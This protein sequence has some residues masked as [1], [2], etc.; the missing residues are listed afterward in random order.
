M[1]RGT[2]WRPDVSGYKD[3]LSL[4]GAASL[5]FSS[6]LARLGAAMIG[7]GVV[8]MLAV[9]DYGFGVAGGV[10]AAGMVALAIC[11]P[12]VGRRL[13]VSDSR[14]FLL[15]VG[16]VATTSLLGL[17]LAASLS[18][19]VW[20]LVLVYLP[21]GVQPQVGGLIRAEW[22]RRMKGNGPALSAAN[23]Y[24]QVVE[25]GCYLAGPALSGLLSALWFPEAGVV[26][27][28]ACFLVGILVL[29]GRYSWRNTRG[30]SSWGSDEEN[31]KAPWRNAPL[32]AVS[33]CA[34]FLGG[35][36]GSYD[37]LAIAA[38]DATGRTELGGLLIGT[39]AAGSL[40]GGLT[41]GLLWLGAHPSSRLMVSLTGLAIATATLPFLP[42]LSWQFPA[43]FAVGVFVA[44][45]LAAVMAW[46]QRL[47]PNG[48]LVEGMSIVSTGILLGVALSS[49]VAGM[50]TERLPFPGDFVVTVAFAVL[51]GLVCAVVVRRQSA[52]RVVA[53]VGGVRAE[54]D[55]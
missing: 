4:S 21:F 12:L 47:V 8:T 30:A 6:A 13:D 52:G 25:E 39:L 28:S 33:V 1:K 54:T 15:M 16:G 36:F 5:M 7:V 48:R 31:G 23:S 35:V 18:A 34:L 9:Q 37:V 53:E 24:E 10:T 19:P 20:A 55:E 51:A 3:L 27:A 17:A 26:V 41:S 49:W 46:A 22:A 50:A 32:L 38:A 14:K 29:G 44:P 43:A 45:S 42:S 11:A 2:R 40:I